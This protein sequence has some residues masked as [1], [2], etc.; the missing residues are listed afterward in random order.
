M[1][2]F[3]CGRNVPEGLQTTVPH[4]LTSTRNIMLFHLGTLY[5]FEGTS[6]LEKECASSSVSDVDRYIIIRKLT[7]FSFQHTFGI[8]TPV[9]NTGTLTQDFSSRKFPI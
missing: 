9:V 5:S 4:T 7:K 2:S 8:H 3:R 6:C 1:T